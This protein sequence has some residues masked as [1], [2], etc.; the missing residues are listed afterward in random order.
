[1]NPGIPSAYLHC[2]FDLFAVH[3][4]EFAASWAHFV[5]TSLSKFKFINNSQILIQL[6]G[7]QSVWEG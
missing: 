5:T 2:S 7:M 1:M 4:G 3:E 6:K